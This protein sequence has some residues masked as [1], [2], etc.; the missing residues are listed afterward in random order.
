MCE[1]DPNK[2]KPCGEDSDCINRHLMTECQTSHCRAKEKCLNQRFQRRQYPPLKVLRT[3]NRGWGLHLL[4][5]VKKG[6]YIRG[7]SLTRN[8][9][10][11]PIF[12]KYM[13]DIVL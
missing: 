4:Q 13:Y 11:T 2:P 9:E 3:Q 10:A 6:T 8:Q 7:I 1:C 5:D 12:I